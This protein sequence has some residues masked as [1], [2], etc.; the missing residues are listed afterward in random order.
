MRQNASDKG[1]DN[2]KLI[3]YEVFSLIISKSFN[4]M[5]TNSSFVATLNVK[6]TLNVKMFYTKGIFLKLGVLNVKLF[7]FM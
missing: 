6:T 5:K 1:L 7:P 2:E 3:L 4:R